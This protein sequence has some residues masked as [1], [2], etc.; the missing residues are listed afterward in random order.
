MKKE[1]SAQVFGN[2]LGPWQP[3]D[4]ISA[5][6]FAIV[7]AVLIML[8]HTNKR[9]VTSPHTPVQF[10]WSFFF[11][12]NAKRIVAGLIL[13]LAGLRFLQPLTTS[14]GIAQEN[15]LVSFFIGAGSDILGLGFQ[16]VLRKYRKKVVAMTE[17]DI[18]ST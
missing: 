1:T 15:M 10:S 13:I 2:L 18:S 17:Q 4:F 9:D 8:L 5:F 14:L 12:D 16:I 11:F 7:G 3:G 6:I